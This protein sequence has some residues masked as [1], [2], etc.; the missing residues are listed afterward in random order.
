MRQLTSHLRDRLLLAAAALILAVGLT[1]ATGAVGQIGKTFPGFL[2]LGNGVVASIGISIWPATED[3]EIFQR[4]IVAADGQRFESADALQAYIRSLPAGTPVDYRFAGAP[5]TKR[6]IETRRFE[7][8]DFFLLHGLY[9]LNGFGLGA[10]ALVCVARRRRTP[11]AQAA[12]PLMFLGAL[13]VLSAMDLYGPYRLFRLH[14]F[15]EAMLFPAALHMALAYPNPAAWLAERR[16]LVPSLYAAGAML[17]LAIEIGLMDAGIYTATHLVAVSAFGLALLVLV[18]SEVDRLRRPL[19]P[20]AYARLRAVALGALLALAIPILVSAMESFTG[21]RSPQNAAAL[22]A[23]L[24]PASVAYAV[25]R[26]GQPSLP[27]VGP[28]LGAAR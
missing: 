15:C 7:L 14:A 10:A 12:T 8:G 19:D 18:V 16:W 6:T 27:H 26:E 25:G 28:A 23:F 21:G 24:F 11:G 2:V 17:G 9:L 22:T 3:G 5:E 13:W 20:D 1:G 4:R